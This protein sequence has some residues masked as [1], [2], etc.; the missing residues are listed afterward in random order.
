[1]EIGD[2]ISYNIS[3][4]PRMRVGNKCKITTNKSKLLVKT[5]KMKEII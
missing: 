1:M 4:V 3:L 2:L 5:W